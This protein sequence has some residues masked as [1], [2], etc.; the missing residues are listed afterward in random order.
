[1]PIEIWIDQVSA[2]Q[3]ELYDSTERKRCFPTI[4]IDREPPLLANHGVDV[5]PRP[6]KRRNVH[7]DIINPPECFSPSLPSFEATSELESHHSGRLSPTKQ[8]AVLEDRDEPVIYCD[9]GSREARIPEDVQNLRADIRALSFGI[10]ILGFTADEFA[11]VM[12][13]ENSLDAIDYACLGHAWINDYTKRRQ[14][15]RMVPLEEV[16]RLVTA[17]ISYE[18]KRAHENAWNEKVHLAILEA[19]LRTSK[20][21]NS[22]GITPV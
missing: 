15:G 16:Q 19:A 1:M 20:H 18:D 13:L 3:Q 22:L 17:A 14:T 10:G 21:S 6:T 11:I 12:G 7:D 9:F 5:T 4:L 2:V 8:L